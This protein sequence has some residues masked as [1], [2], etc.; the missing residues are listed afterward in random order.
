MKVAGTS[1]P[2]PG[3]AVRVVVEY[4]PAAVFNIEGRLLGVAASCTHAGGP[5]EKGP[6]AGTTVTCPGHGSKLDVATG[7]VIRG[8]AARPLKT[9]RVTPEAHGLVVVPV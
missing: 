4:V 7:A 5:I 8:P 2:K 6:I 1:P 3:T 9:F